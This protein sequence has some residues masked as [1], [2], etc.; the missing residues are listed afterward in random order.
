MQ[1][2]GIIQGISPGSEKTPD[3]FVPQSHW[4]INKKKSSKHYLAA[5]HHK[6]RVV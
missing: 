3:T 5:N 4:E 2:V 1:K 6:D